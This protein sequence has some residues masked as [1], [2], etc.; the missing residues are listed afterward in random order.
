MLLRESL[1][2]EAVQPEF[3]YRFKG[4]DYR[5]PDWIIRDGERVTVVEVKKSLLR[6]SSR[7]YGDLDSVRRDLSET[8]GKA[9]RQLVRFKDHAATLPG[10]PA[11]ENMELAVVF[12]EDSWWCNS[13]LQRELS[14]ALKGNVVHAMSASDLERLLALPAPHSLYDALWSKRVHGNDSEA[15]DIADWIAH[16]APGAALVNPFLNRVS[17][18]V[19]KKLADVNDPWDRRT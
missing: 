15:M 18:T 10:M 19:L 1:K 13:L 2:R 9:V 14:N 11:P 16:I 17:T 6:P 5:S 8:L 12:S 3:R 4:A 7:T